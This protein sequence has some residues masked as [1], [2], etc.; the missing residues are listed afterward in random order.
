MVIAPP[1]TQAKIIMASPPAAPATSDGALKMPA[2]MT[3]PTVSM[4]ASLTERTRA[5]R[6]ASPA[7]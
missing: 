1:S 3:T 7:D 4:T 2:P 6:P 5:G